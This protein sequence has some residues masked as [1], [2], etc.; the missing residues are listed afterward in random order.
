MLA[1]AARSY[2]KRYGVR[3]GTRAVLVTATDAA[4]LAA[5]DL[6]AAGVAIAAIADL[7]RPAS[8]PWAED[9]AK[10]AGIQVLAGAA[11]NGTRGGRRVS[12][13]DD[14]RA[15]DRLRPRADVRRLRA[16]GAPLLA[17]ARP[18]HLERRR[19]LFCPVAIRGARAL[20]GRLPRRLRA[21]GRARGRRPW[22]ASRPRKPAGWRAVA[23]RYEVAGE[24][25]AREAP[26]AAPR[27]LGGR[28]PEG[29][30][31]FP[32]RRDDAGPR[33]RRAGRLPLHR[34]REALH[35]R[36]HGDR[37][38]QDLEPERARARRRAHRQ[39]GA[40]GRAHDV[41]HAVHAGDV[42][43]RSQA[44]RAASCST[45]CARRRCTTQPSPAA[46][47]SR[48]SGNGS[49]RAI[50]PRTGEDMHAAVAREC[51]AVRGACGIFDASTLGKIA[52]VGPGRRGVPEPPLR[53]RLLQRSPWDAA[54]TASCC[55]RTASS[56]MTASSRGSRRT[57]ST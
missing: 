53:Q 40:G 33:A 4:Y 6:H 25:P 54:G 13:I 35:D 30:R 38:G 26:G 3:A 28:P 23:H 50:F 48:T 17:V 57:A 22:P 31:G 20:R 49:A 19:A 18:A 36:R 11:V 24:T 56:S 46:R 16:F 29:V 39:A 8:G 14:R 32:E 27:E 21:R 41:P 7:R 10:R 51:R 55:A 37:P 2:L 47:C 15:D 1:G 42:R 43:R 44:A 5:L 12:G 9:A 52:V 45:R 34:A